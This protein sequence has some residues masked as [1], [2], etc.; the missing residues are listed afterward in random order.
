MR[1][2]N[3]QFIR[4][5]LIVF[6]IL[7]SFLFSCNQLSKS[8]PSQITREEQK[9]TVNKAN[10]AKYQQTYGSFFTG[11]SIG[12]AFDALSNVPEEYFKWVFAKHKMPVR[13]CG[14][15]GDLQSNGCYDQYA[16][17]GVAGLTWNDHT[18]PKGIQR[19]PQKLMSTVWALPHEFGHA[20][21]G[22][23]Q[24]WNEGF[25]EDLQKI[26]LI[27]WNKY[28]NISSQYLNS[29]SPNGNNY[30]G[31]SDGD[32]RLDETIAELFDTWYCSETAKKVLKQG[33]PEVYDF[34]QKYFLPPVDSTDTIQD[35]GTKP[36]TDSKTDPNSVKVFIKDE[37][38]VS[39]IYIVDQ[40]GMSGLSYCIGTSEYCSSVS[41]RMSLN[42]VN[43]SSKVNGYRI[44]NLNLMRIAGDNILHI[45]GKNGADIKLLRKLQFKQK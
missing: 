37:G 36:E 27:I 34:A 17:Q 20:S 41:N 39:T 45:Y 28:Q 22:A 23:A 12:Q 2:R 44:E 13:I 18:G 7:T 1:T 16:T 11:N 9:C 35:P 42:K 14:L 4:V 6:M 8:T 32:A 25:W 33:M 21:F 24:E 30:F 5:Y 31:Q 3:Y 15:D 38:S 26:S 29:Y 19:I 10:S 40:K 43:V